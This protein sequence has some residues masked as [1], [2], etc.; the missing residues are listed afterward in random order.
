MYIDWEDHKVYIMTRDITQDIYQDMIE[1]PES[2]GGKLLGGFAY[3][4]ILVFLILFELVA[5][6]FEFL[7]SIKLGK[8]RDDSYTKLVNET[9]KEKKEREAFVKAYFWRTG[10]DLDNAPEEVIKKYRNREKEKSETEERMKEATR[11]YIEKKNPEA[12]N[13]LIKEFNILKKM[14]KGEKK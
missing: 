11:E 8:K 3:G 10:V 4:L 14:L 2:L 12:I 6:P 13:Q 5:V 7:F 1:D 9:W